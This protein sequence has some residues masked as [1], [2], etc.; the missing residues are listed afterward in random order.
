MQPS[1]VRYCSLPNKRAITKAVVHAR[2][3]VTR[4]FFCA[5][6]S[7]AARADAAQSIDSLP[8][9]Q[10][11]AISNGGHSWKDCVFCWRGHDAGH[12]VLSV[13]SRPRYVL[14]AGGDSFNRASSKHIFRGNQ[15]FR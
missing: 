14:H 6:K 3:F 15:C 2:L 4:A 10:I 8:S 13:Y 11:G 7:H 5:H 9:A 1:R 12:V